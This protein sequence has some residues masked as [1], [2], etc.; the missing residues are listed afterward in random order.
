MIPTPKQKELMRMQHEY[1][2]NMRNETQDNKEF[3]Y[4]IEALA[5]IQSRNEQPETTEQKE[6]ENGVN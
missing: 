1:P 4:W 3:G 5:D 2:Q 6:K